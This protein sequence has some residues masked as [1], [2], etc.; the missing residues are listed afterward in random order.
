MDGYNQPF[1]SAMRAASTRLRALSF[2]IA[3]DK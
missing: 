2:W 3:I 1:S